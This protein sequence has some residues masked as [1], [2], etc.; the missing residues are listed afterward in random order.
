MKIKYL[1]FLIVLIVSSTITSQT[2]KR[3]GMLG[4]MM[5]TLTD[6]IAIQNNFNVKTGVHIT[7][8]M[9]NSTFANLGV[10]QDDVLTKLNGLSVSTIQDVLEITSQLYEGDKIEAEY[11]SK[12]KKTEA[13]TVLLG[14]PIETFE[15]G[16]VT[17]GEVVYKDNVLRSILVTPKNK[18]KAPVVYF[19]QGYTCGTVETTTD[20]NPAKK[21]IS[22]WVNAGF[23]VYRVEKPGVGDSKS[24]KHCMQISFDEEL[25]AFIEGYKNLLHN[26]SIDLDNIFM[27]GHSMGGVIAPLLN[28]IKPPRGI[29]TYG[30]V[31]QNWYDYMV[32]LYTLQPKHFG[33]SDSQIREDNKVNLKFNED[34]LI[35]KLSGLEI[36]ENEVYANFFRDNEINFRQNQYI[37]RHFDFWQ[38][39]ADI[40][41][42]NAWSKVKTNVLA[43][44][45]EFDIQAI[46]PKGA[47]KIAEIVNENGGKGDFV[48]VANAD[49]GFVNFNSMQHNVETLGNG[50]YMLHARDNYSVALGKETIKWMLSKIEN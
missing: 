12:N 28:D 30:S 27:F 11:Y 33:V 46:S 21:L 10:K 37:G 1:F 49:H 42:P 23:A 17:Y 7:T 26:D 38:S 3:K 43:M 44:H 9:P 13:S 6:S 5:Q 39:L 31:A 16:I 29:I 22:D 36:L 34:F 15:N 20:D 48:L 18:I 19:L 45:G 24:S 25:L 4:V 8:V 2:L 32:E 47:Q 35:N 14:R 40:D 41:I 50:S